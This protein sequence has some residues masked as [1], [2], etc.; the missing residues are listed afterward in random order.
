MR[1]SPMQRATGLARQNPRDFWAECRNFDPDV[2]QS[3]E[4]K[5]DWSFCQLTIVDTRH[6][7]TPQACVKSVGTPYPRG[8]RE[9][10]MPI[11][12]DFSDRVTLITGAARG[13]GRVMVRQF[14]EAGS[15]VLADDRSEAGIAGSDA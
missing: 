15:F 7:I 3:G 9:M 11:A 10:E 12:F 4:L 14:A 1:T 8:M 2:N 5:P 13:V 6:N